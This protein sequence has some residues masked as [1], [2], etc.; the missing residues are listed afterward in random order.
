MRYSPPTPLPPQGLMFTFFV[1]ESLVQPA[2]VEI[3]AATQGSASPKPPG[4]SD[5]PRDGHVLPSARRSARVL[6]ARD[7]RD[8]AAWRGIIARL[9]NRSAPIRG[10]VVVA[11]SAD[12]VASGR[13]M[14]LPFLF[15][16]LGALL[17]RAS[18]VTAPIFRSPEGSH[19][20]MDT[21]AIAGLERATPHPAGR[22][23]EVQDDSARLEG[24]PACL[25]VLPRRRT[26]LNSPSF[27]SAKPQN[28]VMKG[29]TCVEG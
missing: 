9:T 2:A 28:D 10:P 4:T 13:T 29:A 21:A 17:R 1:S 18:N 27:K 11:E 25:E 6:M 12:H 16:P 24:T 19:H 23:P 3:V 15:A 7:L 22:V 14:S 5:A 8:S 20:G 26:S